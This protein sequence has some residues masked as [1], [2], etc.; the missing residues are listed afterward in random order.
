MFTK[1]CRPLPRAAGQGIEHDM[2]PSARRYGSTSPAH[3][4]VVGNVWHKRARASAHMLRTPRAWAVDLA[5]LEAAERCGAKFVCIVD[6]ESGRRHWAALYTLRRQGFRL[7][8]G[9]GDQVALVLDRWAASKAEASL[10]D[11][12]GVEQLTLGL[13]VTP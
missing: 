5:D 1:N 11:A 7:N 3:G 6:V 13:E 8:R 12:D 4:Q 2:G 10:A 9:W